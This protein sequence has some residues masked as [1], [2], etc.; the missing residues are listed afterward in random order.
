MAS[1][2]IPQQPQDPYAN[3]RNGP[4]QQA[5]NAQS[6]ASGSLPNAA[7]Q[8]VGAKTGG[9][10]FESLL[11]HISG[12][13]A[14]RPQAQ[15]SGVS[16]G[17][18]PNPQVPPAPGPQGAYPQFPVAPNG[19]GIQPVSSTPQFNGPTGTYPTFPVAP[20]GGGIVPNPGIPQFNGPSGPFLVPE[21]Q[22]TVPGT[23]TI[24]PNPQIPQSSAQPGPFVVPQNTPPPSYSQ[25]IQMPKQFAVQAAQA[26][27]FWQN[28][29]TPIGD[30]QLTPGTDP[31]TAPAAPVEPPVT[32]PPAG[33]NPLGPPVTGTDPVSGPTTE[34]P[35][36]QGY[37]NPDDWAI[38][39]NNYAKI[40]PEQ[41]GQYAGITGQDVTNYRNSGFQ[42]HTDDY[43][44]LGLHR[45]PYYQGGGVPKP[46]GTENPAVAAQWYATFKGFE[47]V[48]EG[49]VI[50]YRNSGFQGDFSEWYMKGRPSPAA[51]Q[52][53]PG[54]GGPG[55]NYPGG[56]PTP[57][58]IAPGQPGFGDK[59]KPP[60]D[61]N[62]PPPATPT[63]PTTPPYEM[64]QSVDDFGTTK[65]PGALDQGT[66]WDE[67][68]K[69][70]GDMLN[71]AF[72]RMQNQ[73]ARAARAQAALTG[74]INSGGFGANLNEGLSGLSAQQSALL[75]DFASKGY[76]A[77]KERE[78]TQ[79]VESMKDA[80]ARFGINTN[81]DLEK[82]LQK[83]E[84]ELKK[85]GI[86]KDDL[87]QRYKAQLDLEGTK[88]S[89][90]AGVRAASLHAAA[91]AAAANASAAAAKYGADV[92]RDLGLLN[93]DID[94]ENNIMR[95]ILGLYGT[96][97]DQLRNLIA[98]SPDSWFND[99]NIP[100]D[101]IIKP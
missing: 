14:M 85:W 35:N 84:L 77:Q 95:F 8:G 81:A 65:P 47:G 92:Q 100:G 98:T 61:P 30:K 91:S 26:D 68:V 58:A 59:P 15:A 36:W 90:D 40:A 56:A 28:A 1:F 41:F 99:M 60:V 11:Q 67:I 16:T 46:P 45:N 89:A 62:A 53:T 9:N 75:G 54:P 39:A 23:G 7:M 97:N 63:T 3:L 22:F 33:G 37:E 42:G 5:Q 20:N 44:R 88:Y 25:G 64:T 2:Y 69:K 17:P 79:F 19:G 87:L 82:F 49:D 86:E 74:E 52:P 43:F 48:T 38:A 55:S 29:S 101:V 66:T 94:R 57:G 24:I 51:P 72:E 32:P 93:A 78:L 31:G 21:Q 80:T 12:F 27:T 96:G 73:Y 6:G 83:N 76:E 13:N 70:Y 18:Q 71:H 34:L 4:Q 50:A 10:A